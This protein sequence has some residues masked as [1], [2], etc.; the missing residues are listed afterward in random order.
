MRYSS[1]FKKTFALELSSEMAYK[2]N[3]LI[4]SFALITADLIGPLVMMLIYTNSSGIPG[5]SFEE[6]LLFQGTFIFVI[7]LSHFLL[8][9][10]PVHVIDNVREGTFDKILIKPYNP[11][12]YL[13]FTS[14][15]LEGLAEVFGGL[16]LIIYS[17]IK[18]DLNL[19]SL[20]TI[21][22]IFLILMAFVFLYGCFILMSSLAFLFV[23][24]FGL[25]D[26]FFKIM[27]VARY[28]INIY[29]GGMRFLFTFIIPIGI[30]SFYPASVLLKELS[31]ISVGSV[32]VIILL[33]LVFSIW[34]W[35]KAIRKYTSAGG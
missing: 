31:V 13:S 5:W 20:N 12:M 3:F 26:L 18:L 28:P 34:M 29:E 11:L 14:I 32:L 19:F 27:D 2:T 7:G 22:Y 15:D 10:I 17:F 4:K 25:F 1:L 30:V 23:K 33:F 24:S 9:M 6:F 35:N 8:M 16:F 21:F